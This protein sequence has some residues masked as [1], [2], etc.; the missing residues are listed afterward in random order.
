MSVDLE[1]DEQAGDALLL[2][3]LG[4]QAGQPGPQVDEVEAESFWAS[5]TNPSAAITSVKPKCRVTN[6]A[7]AAGSATLIEMAAPVICTGS[8]SDGGGN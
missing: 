7:E 4:L 8:P 6:A 3:R 1:G 2:E 5:E